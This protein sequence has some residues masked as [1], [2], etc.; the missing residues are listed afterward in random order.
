MRILGI[1]IG[2]TSIK[3][4]ELDS[5]F[6]RYEIHEYHEHPIEQ[7]DG[8]GAQAALAKLVATLPK[9][10]DK[11]AVALRTKEVTFRNLEL[12]T[13]DKKAI[14]AAIGFELDD[15][16]PFAFEQAA[17]D[18][19]IL[20]SGRRSTSAHVAV[21][22]RRYLSESLARWQEASVDPDLV[23]TEA[24]AFR[25]LLNRVLNPAAQ[26]SP[27]LVAQIGHDRTVLYL[28]WRGAPVLCREVPWGGKELTLALAR[29]YQVHVA[30]AEQTKVDHGFV[31]PPS[32]RADATPEQVDF[33]DTLLEP[34]QQL[35]WHLRQAK[36]A[37]KSHTQ[38]HL[39][40]I[41][42]SGG[43]SSLPGFARF[44]EESLGL[45]VQPLQALGSIATSGV[46]YTERADATFLTAVALALCLV[47]PDRASVINFRRGS[48]SK[49][50]RAR[51]L[52]L[53]T[54]R[55]PALAAIAVIACFFASLGVQST[56]YKRRLADVDRRVEENVKAFFGRQLSG[57]AV[58]N[59]LASTNT[60][61][62][63]VNKELTKKRDLA[64]LMAPNPHS[65][66]DFLKDISSSIPRD[67]VVD[68]TQFQVG[69]APASPYSAVDLGDASLTFVFQNPQ[70][71]ERLNALLSSSLKPLQKG[72]VEEIS[73][74]G[75]SPRQWKVTFTGKPLE[76]T[77]GK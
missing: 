54:L 30:Q 32:Q 15:D 45:P 51:E 17:Y 72:K 53:S 59:Y 1:D 68:L 74:Q 73:A 43:T 2:T 41:Y 12:P 8:N 21:T 31:I 39:A 69:A 40:Q 63:S 42:L 62:A 9:S 35:I 36:V 27:A 3:A 34:I 5:A 61:K 16:L 38:V 76:T 57:S 33:S 19:T 64:R 75:D 28:Q 67:L 66:I 13:R 4:V 37:C 70:T 71:A 25:A 49:H 48:F 47:G 7:T 24:S 23:T 26:E 14:Q 65:A 46:T 60:L 56:V 77:Y 18:Y 11:I 55:R 58:R 6:G 22:L 20:A 44:I 50:G 29:R 52:N 10:P